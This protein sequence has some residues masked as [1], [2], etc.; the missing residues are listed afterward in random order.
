[1]SLTIRKFG[2]GS[3]TKKQKAW[4]GVLK[5][6]ASL[7]DRYVDFHD[8]DPAPYAYNE[9]ANVGLLAGAILLHDKK[10]HC[11]EEY[12]AQKRNSTGRVDLWAV[13]KKETYLAEAKF[14]WSSCQSGTPYFTSVNQAEQSELVGARYLLDTAIEKATG[15]TSDEPSFHVAAVFVVPY[16]TKCQITE[17]EDVWK[18]I[19][20][21][22]LHLGSHSGF[23]A[24][25]RQDQREV[26]ATDDEERYPGVI[27]FLSFRN[28]RAAPE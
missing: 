20:G 4:K 10:N 5:E 27:L 26:A 11:L 9:R 21:E 6:W 3:V 18:Q 7:M 23:V 17:A 16:I 2:Q 19:L 8:N 24:Y 28:Y 12:S 14:G 25:Y 1:M 13:V 15:Y 22:D